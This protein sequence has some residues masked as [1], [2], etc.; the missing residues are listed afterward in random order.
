MEELQIWGRVRSLLHQKSPHTAQALAITLESWP[1]PL[2]QAAELRNYIL[3][4]H[5]DW[6]PSTQAPPS[7]LLELWLTG[8]AFEL[9]ELLCS[10]SRPHTQGIKK[11]F[12]S[13]LAFFDL[14]AR[15]D[16]LD[17][18]LADIDYEKSQSIWDWA[19]ARGKPVQTDHLYWHP[20]RDEMLPLAQIDD[21]IRLVYLEREDSSFCPLIQF[22][23]LRP[24]SRYESPPELS[25]WFN[26]GYLDLVFWGDKGCSPLQ[27][28]SLFEMLWQFTRTESP[29][30]TLS[31]GPAKSFESCWTFFAWLMQRW[32]SAVT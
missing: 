11:H 22:T 12:E 19:N 13:L 3:D 24:D 8:Q 6:R 14:L 27:L 9:F 10:T 7:E 26:S 28:I 18:T 20:E 17:I 21:V 16:E 1:R 25:L 31:H 2:I 5:P 29:V 32:D 23:D 15:E 30:P 4:F